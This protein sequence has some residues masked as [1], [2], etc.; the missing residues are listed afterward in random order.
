MA[1]GVKDLAWSPLCLGSLP[2]L[3]LI[4]GE[5]TF[6][7]DGCSQ[8]KSVFVILG[9]NTCVYANEVTQGGPLVYVNQET[10]EGPFYK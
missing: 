8:K 10:F 1:Q 3:R 2:W 9:E 4:P 5:E 6:A 7:C